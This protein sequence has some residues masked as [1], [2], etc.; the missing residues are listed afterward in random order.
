MSAWASFCRWLA[1]PDPRDSARQFVPAGTQPVPDNFSCPGE[2]TQKL[3]S[4]LPTQP[5]DYEAHAARAKARAR[6]RWQHKEND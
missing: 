2:D 1:R 3:Y 4:N 5:E 6:A